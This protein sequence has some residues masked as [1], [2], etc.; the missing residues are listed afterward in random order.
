MRFGPQE[1]AAGAE[2]NVPPR[3]SQSDHEEPFQ[4]LWYRALSVPFTNTSR[5]LAAHEATAGAEV[6][7]PPRFSQSIH[8][9]PFQYYDTEHCPF[10]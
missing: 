5:R 2:V 9:E 8:W 6:K 3:F 1:T 10:L 4:Y 7:T